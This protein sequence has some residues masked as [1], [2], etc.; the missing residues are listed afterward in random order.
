ESPV[1]APSTPGSAVWA[2]RAGESHMMRL[3]ELVKA[4]ERRG[5][6][7]VAVEVDGRELVLSNLD[8]VMY[9]A[10]GFTKGDVIDYYLQIAPTML[11][12]LA[13]RPVTRRRY[14]DGV[15]AP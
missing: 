8:K 14:P 7:R 1:P 4:G 2:C 11:T 6:H 15:T 9:P 13:D 10:D 12:H 3:A 5:K